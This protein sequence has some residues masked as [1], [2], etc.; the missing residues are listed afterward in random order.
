MLQFNTV[1]QYL[2]CSIQLG[3]CPSHKHK[4]HLY[5]V[6]KLMTSFNISSM[7]KWVN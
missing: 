1:L 4:K 7:G 2:L 3:F 5:D 6:T